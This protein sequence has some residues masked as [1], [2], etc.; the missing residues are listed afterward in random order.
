M[1]EGA[2]TPK[3]IAGWIKAAITSVFGLVSGA[4]LMYVTPL[5]DTVIK[6]AKPVANFAAQ[7]QGLNVTFNNR[8][9]GGSQ[10]WWDFGDGSALEAFSPQQDTISHTFPAP[11]TYTVKLSIHNLIGEQNERDVNIDLKS[12]KDTP[13]GPD[14]KDFKVTQIMPGVFNVSARIENA[15]QCIWGLGDH[16]PLSI[17]PCVNGNVERVVAIEKPGR[18]VLRLV[19]VNGADSKEQAQEVVGPGTPVAAT[20]GACARLRVTYEAVDI[21]RQVLQ[22]YVP[23]TWSAGAKDNTS[24]FEVKRLLD[25]AHKDY[26]I[27][28]ADV[29][30]KADSQ[31]KNVRVEVTPDKKSYVLRGDMVHPS[32]WFNLTKQAPSTWVA[33]VALNIEKRSKPRAVSTDEIPAALTVP[34]TTPIAIP[35]VPPGMQATQKRL[36]LELSD[37]NRVVWSGDQPPANA[38]VQIGSRP[39]RVSAVDQG[40]RLLL[41]VQDSVSAPRPAGN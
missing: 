12:G 2:E 6:P 20:G 26:L 1:A 28:A 14:V 17:T 18:H 11:G 23:V 8:S 10:G 35:A 15:V 29:V 3:G 31:V 32:R 24:P 27:L 9:L 39:V 13:G 21:D 4:V 33:K 16:R 25:N 7:V 41:Q 19:A 34:G 40:N 5:V 30:N 37:G 22:P 38:V 36:H